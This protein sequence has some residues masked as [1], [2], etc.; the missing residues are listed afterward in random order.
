M[1]VK[2]G[3]NHVINLNLMGEFWCDFDSSC[4][5]IGETA[6]DSG[7]KRVL[8]LYFENEENMLKV[9]GE[10]IDGLKSNKNYIDISEYVENVE[11]GI[12]G[13]E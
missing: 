8:L 10:L 6:F 7:T 4:I 3:D 1:W 9:Y 5:V 12:Y 2:V 11:E 13:E